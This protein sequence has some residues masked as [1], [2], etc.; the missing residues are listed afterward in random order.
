MRLNKQH[1]MCTGRLLLLYMETEHACAYWRHS[2]VL[3]RYLYSEHGEILLRCVCI[4]MGGAGLAG[5]V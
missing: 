3:L 5:T 1:G 2:P 4:F